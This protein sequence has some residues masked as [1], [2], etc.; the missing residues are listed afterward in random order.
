M[1][2]TQL[3]VDLKIPFV[4]GVGGEKAEIS[5]ITIKGPSLKLI[6]PA[7]ALQAMFDEP[8]RIEV[9]EALSKM[10]PE[11]FE[12]ARNEAK[13]E[14]SKKDETAE[15]ERVGASVVL[16]TIAKYRDNKVGPREAIPVALGYL[17]ELMVGGCATVA[18]GKNVTDAMF[19]KIEFVDAKNILGEYV[20]AFLLTSL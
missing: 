13:N 12:H 17:K 3:D 15:P 4:A 14:Q 16:A 11:T 19:D 18:E 20:S 5:R 8:Q 6:K 1:Y 2:T 9:E 10:T 7:A